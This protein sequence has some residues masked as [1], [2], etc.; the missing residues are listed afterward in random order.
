MNMKKIEI[1]SY[2]KEE[3]RDLI[4]EID[5]LREE[6]LNKATNNYSPILGDMRTQQVKNGDIISTY[7]GNRYLMNTFVGVVTE[8]KNMGVNPSRARV[9]IQLQNG[10]RLSFFTN[11]DKYIKTGSIIEA[12]GLCFKNDNGF[13]DF[14]CKGGYKRIITTEEINQI[15][16]GV[17]FEDLKIHKIPWDIISNVKQSE[18][19]N[20]L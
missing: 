13:Y 9:V 2:T 20:T 3:V 5:S 15:S 16:R 19:I 7:K 10:K 4:K 12:T 11:I 1:K 18:K 8:I 17:S 6:I 14:R